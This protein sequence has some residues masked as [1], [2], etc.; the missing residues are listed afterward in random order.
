MTSP[1]VEIRRFGASDISLAHELK[2]LA[3]WN[4]TEADWRGYLEFE[5]EGCFVAEVDGEPAGTATTIRYAGRVGWIGMVLVHPER[6]RLG[7]GT[8]LLRHA[9]EYLRQNGTAC[10]K[11]D[12]TPMGKKV[13]VPLGF[14]DEYE[15]SRFEGTAP[16]IAK[17]SDE[18]S[19]FDAEALP[20]LAA[21]DARAFG[22]DRTRVLASMGR[23]D[24]GLCFLARD[25]EG[26][27]GY[28]IAREGH[29]ALQLGPWIARDPYVAEQL[30][31]AFFHRVPGRR[32]LVDVPGP[33]R[34]G[35]EQIERWGFTVQRGFTRMFLGENLF[36]GDPARVF[37]TG[38]A[39][40]G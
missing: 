17:A 33:N 26:I 9:I 18:V 37:G 22:A 23:R 39:E 25:R 32:V 19:M 40:K 10:I 30:L 27:S 20:Q 3:G 1:S 35:R 21:F 36:P 8:R 11:L 24:P 7:I 12:A 38:G 16:E 13:Y 2:N 28:L 15:I 14:L 31:L 4:Q 29:R 6:R 5:P 34:A